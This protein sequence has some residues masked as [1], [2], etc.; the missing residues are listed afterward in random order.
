MEHSDI[1]CLRCLE[2]S[3][4]YEKVYLR[5]LK[6]LTFNVQRPQCVR[7]LRRQNVQRLVDRELYVFDIIARGKNVGPCENTTSNY[8]KPRAIWITPSQRLISVLRAHTQAKMPEGQQM[9]HK[10]TPKNWFWFFK[11]GFKTQRSVV[12]LTSI[13]FGI[14]YFFRFFAFGCEKKDDS[15]VVIREA[16]SILTQNAWWDNLNW[17]LGKGEVNGCCGVTPNNGTLSSYIMT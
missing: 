4:L 11:K 12:E 17:D 2:V 10:N 13:D 16:G 15:R 5:F 6:E 14:R 8:P 3:H 9:H 7:C 1:K